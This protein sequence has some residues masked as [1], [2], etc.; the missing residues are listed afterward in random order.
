MERNQINS[1]QEAALTQDEVR[2]LRVVLEENKKRIIDSAKSGLELSMNRD[3]D[4]GRDSI[5][6]STEEEILST[7]LRLRDREKQLLEKIDK[8]LE[9]LEDGTINECE[10]CGQ[11]IGFKRLVVRP[12]TTL[13]IDCKEDREV[14]E[15][16]LEVGHR[17]FPQ[18]PTESN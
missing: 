14:H 12:V 13:C 8:A 2:E 5:D 17:R 18:K 10:D 3:T 1:E 11:S 15:E 7:A 9:R 4:V 16:M 6:E